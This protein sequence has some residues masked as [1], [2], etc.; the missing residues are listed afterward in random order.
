LCHRSAAAHGNA[1]IG[2]VER[3]RIVDSVWRK[4]ERDKER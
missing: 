1:D 2:S 4:E 3:W